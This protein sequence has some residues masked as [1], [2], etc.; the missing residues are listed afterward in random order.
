[1]IPS[2]IS[3]HARRTVNVE[4]PPI[5]VGLVVPSK[6]CQEVCHVLGYDLRFDDHIID[7]D[8]DVLSNLLLEN[9]VH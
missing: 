6:F 5:R 1:M 7:I 2:P 9:L 3:F 4:A 8:F